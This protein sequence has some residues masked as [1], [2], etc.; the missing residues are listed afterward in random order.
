MLGVERVP[1]MDTDIHRLCRMSRATWAR[2]IR[3]TALRSACTSAHRGSRPISGAKDPGAV[4]AVLA[5][6]RRS[7]LALAVLRAVTVGPAIVCVAG[8]LSRSLAD[9]ASPAS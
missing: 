7:V 5:P 8:P 3:I 4:L 9:D 6:T 1:Y 2:A